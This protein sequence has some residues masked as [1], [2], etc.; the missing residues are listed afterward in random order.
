MKILIA[1]EIANS[2][3]KLLKADY[4]VVVH[5]YSPNELID[6]ISKFHALIVRS[7]TKVPR[8]VIEKG[9]NLKAIGRAGVGID[10]IDVVAATERKIAVV[11]SPHASTISVAEMS[12][13]FM[14]A[15]SR[16]LVDAN[17]QTKLG[18]WPKNALMGTEL[19]AKTLG[20][21]GCGRIGAEVAKRAQ[22]FGMRCIA[23]D[24]YL[25]KEIAKS[26]NVELFDDLNYVLATSDF[27]SIHALLTDETYGMI[28]E[29]ELSIMKSSSFIINCARGGIIDE[30]ALYEALIERRIKGVALDVFEIEPAK[31]NKLFELENVYVSPHIAASTIEAQERAGEIIA[32]Q[33][34][35]VLQGNRPVFCVNNEIFD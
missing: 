33:I 5:H 21:I 3:V 12:L 23:Y 4:D 28:G 31:E 35:F 13:G 29:K 27:V 22:S 15:L 32:E 11:N 14:L 19:Y 9:T 7:A 18:R 20:F 2:A 6:E 1:D 26:I 24:P 30:K 17:Y 8:L 16:K 25:P 10:N 34:R